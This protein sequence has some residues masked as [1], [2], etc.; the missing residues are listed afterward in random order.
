[1]ASRI[2]HDWDVTPKEAIEI[3]KLLEQKVRTEP[4]DRRTSKAIRTIAG[5]DVSLNLYESDIYAGIVVLS[6]PELIPIGR[7]LVKSRT[8]FPYVPGLLS[9]REVPA[10][11][12]CFELLQ[13]QGLTP[14]MVMVDGQGIAHPRRLGI[15]THFGI[16]ADVPTIGCAKSPLF[17]AYKEP[18]ETGGAEDII[19]P[20]TGEKIG[21]AFKSKDRSR[22]LIVS[23]GHMVS[24]EE[25]LEIVKNCIKGYRLPEP[26]R[27][28]HSIT[29]QFRRGEIS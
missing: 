22:P 14:D 20:R 12:E 28:A 29:N 24:I 10:L 23:P 1:M 5:A 11:M 17:G 18:T 8:T 25:A 3:Q 2:V 16:L 27:L 7:A 19:D 4:F 6:Y 9:F 21:R 15:A 26:T 13:K